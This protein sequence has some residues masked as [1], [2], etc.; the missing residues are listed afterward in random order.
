MDLRLYR[1]FVA[2]AD[3][4][5]F[6]AAAAVLSVTQPA[7]TKQIQQLERMV[8]APL[9]E[10]GRFG[11]RLTEAGRRLLDDARDLVDRADRLQDRARRIAAGQEGRLAVGFGLSSISVAPRA[12][13]RFRQA[14]PDVDVTLEDMSSAEQ[15]AQLRSGG[16]DL[17]FV[18]LPVDASLPHLAALEDGLAIAYPTEWDAPVDDHGLADWLG[19]HPLVL[20]TAERGPGLARQIRSL[21]AELGAA[22]RVVQTARDIQTVLALVAAQIGAAIVPAS[23]RHIA[24][25]SVGMRPLALASARWQVGV[26]WDPARETP[27]VGAF[28]GLMSRGD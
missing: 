18:R 20:L 7:L 17:G 21:F 26:V 8:G 15:V 5:S 19:R 12:V 22:P 27:A 23:A 11:S 13:A 2:T 9:F 28:L 1:A 16:I 10:R 6:G 14:F 24:P 25:V 3:A 4:S